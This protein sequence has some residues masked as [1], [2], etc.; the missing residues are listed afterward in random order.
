MNWRIVGCAVLAVTAFV[1]LGLASLWLVTEP[2]GCPE[3]LQWADR[4]YAADGS[5]AP[6]PSLAE[7]TPV[8]IGSTFIG[9]TT[10]DVYAPPGSEPTASAA[11]RPDVLVLDC[12]DGSF[13]AYRYR[14]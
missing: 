2:A 14:P 10:R 8:R 11:T 1:G 7:G 13:R 6:E 5:P 12:G 3:G 9:M 4:T